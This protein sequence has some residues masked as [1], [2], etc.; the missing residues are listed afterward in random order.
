MTLRWHG[1]ARALSF[2]VSFAFAVYAAT[3]LYERL[4]H[5]D[6]LLAAEKLEF[7]EPITLPLLQR[8]RDQSMSVVANGACTADLLMAGLTLHLT[9][10]DSVDRNRDYEAWYD[11]AEKADRFTRHALS[12]RPSDANIWLRFAMIDWAISPD[13]RKL[14]ASLER[15]SRLSPAE[16]RLVA[17]RIG[18]LARQRDF[19]RA[20]ASD[21][22][23]RDVA[24]A[25]G[26]GRDL[27]I[28]RLFGPYADALAPHAAKAAQGLDPQR[29][30]MLRNQ[31]VRFDVEGVLQGQGR[32]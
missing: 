9:M 8:I 15:S 25:L 12:C 30:E 6:I 28:G 4:A 3:M 18:F 31:G 7:E 13:E 22:L 17:A 2:S 23:D 14:V 24:I 10:L 5:A 32:Q 16:W 26:F 21:V 19:V 11:T 29:L 20:A 1:Y 27:D